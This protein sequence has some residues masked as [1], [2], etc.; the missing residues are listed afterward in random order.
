[1]TAPADLIA[2]SSPQDT[3]MPSPDEGYRRLMLTALR[4]ARAK[5]RLILL[6]IDDIGTELKDGRIGPA[7][8]FGR[9]IDG[10]IDVLFPRES[11][12]A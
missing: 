3:P 9:C 11:D 2:E 12:G 10:K 5:L 8:A 7:E 4:I 1:M 6:E